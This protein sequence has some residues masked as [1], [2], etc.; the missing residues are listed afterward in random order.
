MGIRFGRKPLLIPE[1]IQKV[2]KLRKAGSQPFGGVVPDPDMAGLKE[3]RQALSPYGGGG[4]SCRLDKP[5]KRI[6]TSCEKGPDLTAQ[7]HDTRKTLVP[8][9]DSFT[10]HSGRFVLA[11][12][13]VDQA[14]GRQGYV[15]ENPAALVPDVTVPR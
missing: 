13:G 12:T 9:G 11:S 15:A 4:G 1:M 10:L 5:A 14:S 7:E 3:S 2:R 8:F 6:L